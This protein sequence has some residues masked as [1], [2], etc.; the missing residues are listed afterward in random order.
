VIGLNLIL[1]LVGIKGA[2]Y[3]LHHIIHK[4]G[5]SA[6]YDGVETD[7]GATI[8]SGFLYYYF[9][10]FL[11]SL[12]TRRRSAS[13]L[14][15]SKV[16]TLRVAEELGL[17]FAAGLASKLISTPLSVI[18]VRLQTEREDAEDDEILYDEEV[19]KVGGI[20]NVIGRIYKEDGLVGFWRGST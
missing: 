10:S 20:N 14:P 11:R 15:K 19:K 4:H 9:Y 8:I 16:P 6:L 7:T 3:L 18:T 5:L 12:L 2:V 13:S 1:Q 17:G